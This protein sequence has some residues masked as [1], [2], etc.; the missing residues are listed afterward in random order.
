MWASMD[1]HSK[2]MGKSIVLQCHSGIVVKL[3]CVIKSSYYSRINNDPHSLQKHRSLYV[4]F[5]GKKKILAVYG[6]DISNVT[7]GSQGR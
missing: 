4:L 6:A 7:E 1:S 3:F 2:T 5:G